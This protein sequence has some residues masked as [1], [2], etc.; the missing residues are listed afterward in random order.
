MTWTRFSA[1]TAAAELA[2]DSPVLELGVRT[3]AGCAELRV[4]PVRFFLGFRLVLS[5]VRELRIA[6]SLVALIS[7]G[8][9]AGGLQLVAIQPGI[10]AVRRRAG[11]TVRL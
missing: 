4:G 9:Q 7:Q 11:A 6:A 5:P 8:D 10:M 2:Q 1:R 3:F